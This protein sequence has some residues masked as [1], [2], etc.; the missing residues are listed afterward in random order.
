MGTILLILARKKTLE[1]KALV[2]F[3]GLFLDL[4]VI[5]LIK[6]G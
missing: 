3:I 5:L 4:V 2:Y 6:R 1:T